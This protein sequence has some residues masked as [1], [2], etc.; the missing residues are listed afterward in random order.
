MRSMARLNNYGFSFIELA[1]AMLLVILLMGIVSA[2]KGRLAAA[3]G[4]RTVTEIQGILNAAR[5]YYSQ[6]NNTW[7]STMAQLQTFIPHI[8]VN[9]AGNANN[10]FGNQYVLVNNGS[11]FAVQTTVPSK[12]TNLIKGGSFASILND[13]GVSS[14]IQCTTTAPIDASVGRIQYDEKHSI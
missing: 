4:E 3:Q 2:V 14:N 5:E 1:I 6:N 7:P 11:T 12:A 9:A 8:V 13:N 10:I